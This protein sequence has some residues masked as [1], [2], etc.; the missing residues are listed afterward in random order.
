MDQ[1]QMDAEGMS[2][3]EQ[4][5]SNRRLFWA[6]AASVLLIVSIIFAFI[7]YF[8]LEAI[9]QLRAQTL[10]GS[11]FQRAAT[12]LGLSAV[13][14]AFTPAI[15]KAIMLA[16][17][18]GLVAT[19]YS[20]Y[21][22]WHY[23][24]L[25]LKS[26]HAE[27]EA[28]FEDL[29]NRL[30]ERDEQLWRETVNFGFEKR[31]REPSAAAEVALPPLPKPAT[32]S[33]AKA[34]VITPPAP[35]EPEAAPRPSEWSLSFITENRIRELAALPRAQQ[36]H[37]H[38]D[39]QSLVYLS[40]R[41]GL[42]KIWQQGLA[43]GALPK[44]LSNF[45]D[46]VEALRW[47]PDGRWLACQVAPGGGLNSQV[48]ALRAD[49]SEA[50]LISSG[51]QSHNWLGGWLAA[52]PTL[53]YLSNR[54]SADCLH[55]YAHHLKSGETRRLTRIDNARPGVARIADIH[56]GEDGAAL[57][58]ER[59]HHRSDSNVYWLD[60]ASGAE[61]LLT[62]HEGPGHFSNARFH[63]T[64]K[65]VYLS[66]DFQRDETAFC[67][68]HLGENGIP[69]PLETL[70]ARE[71]I[72]LDRFALAADGEMAALSWNIAGRN[73]LELLDLKTGQARPIPIP[74]AE[75]IVDLEFGA[76]GQYLAL[77]LSGA[78]LAGDI[79]LYRRE[80]GALKRFT[81]SAPPDFDTQALIQ[82]ELRRF[83]AH[84]GLELSGWLY[85][86]RGATTAGP[87]VLHF[88]GGPEGQATPRY[89]YDFQALLASGISVFDP[90]VRGSSGFGKSFANLDN[91]GL[92]FNALR[93]IE[94]CARHLL[95]EGIAAPGQLGIMGAS[96]G[97]YMTMAGLT[98]YPQLFAAAANLFGIVNFFTFFEQT[99][100][101]MAA[102]STVK[103][104]DPQ[105][106]ADLLRN[107]S[108]IF[109]LEQ[110]RTPTL[111]LHGANDQNVPV[112]EAEQVV[113][114]LRAREV[115]CKYRL[116]EDEGHGWRRQENKVLSTLDIVD[117]FER[118]LKG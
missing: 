3:E 116:F 99:T 48:Y 67:R 86:A 46:P 83:T 45:T 112:A 16:Q 65:A 12:F 85:R 95:D 21:Q 106:Q 105:T 72:I 110:V 115:P 71:K 49:G 62:P 59:V 33:E 77:S 88:H 63:P 28:R 89:R 56:E 60:C 117:W 25:K 103:Y 57:L 38:P 6:Y 100:P 73:E 92:R 47:S 78:S 44:A 61:V 70:H 34:D 24:E 31:L 64:G 55:V 9:Q 20:A 43:N 94:S 41:D 102:I 109:K 53:L 26:R 87:V 39:G 40:D 82:P 93:D 101:W 4:S 50:Y 84:D 104:G 14:G 90:N 54:E 66:A 36:A 10:G 108:P 30:K 37:F 1:H 22:F 80:T 2:A 27:L 58:L 91:G 113:N 52:G 81:H 74:A 23:S 69:K 32:L 96:Y 68:I 111:V 97:G 29:Q 75:V 15:G 13:V 118:H 76:A 19:G 51:G 107:L 17:A 18:L 79:W 42:P 114:G 5:L 7:T 8:G 35:P 11:I 98:E